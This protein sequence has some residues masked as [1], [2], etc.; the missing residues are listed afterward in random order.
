MIL[1]AFPILPIFV[2]YGATFSFVISGLLQSRRLLLLL[3]VHSRWG[4][5]GVGVGGAFLVFANSVVG[6]LGVGKGGLLL[7]FLWFFGFGISVLVA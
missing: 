4:G 1:S 7:L 3:L 2:V 5:L 6:G